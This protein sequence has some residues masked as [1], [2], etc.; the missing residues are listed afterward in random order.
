MPNIHD[1]E[2]NKPSWED[3]SEPPVNVL[4]RTRPFSRRT[5]FLASALTASGMKL[6][7]NS[8]TSIAFAQDEF[9]PGMSEIGPR[10]I[11]NKSLESGEY[12]FVIDPETRERLMT[13]VMNPGTLRQITDRIVDIR[14]NFRAEGSLL[15]QSHLTTP[16]TYGFKLA[17]GT[18][19]EVRF[20]LTTR[21]FTDEQIKEV[22]LVGF[23]WSEEQLRK[24]QVYGMNYQNQPI[25]LD[26]RVT[27]YRH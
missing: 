3:V 22:N 10:N 4:Q 19:T 16:D 5:L 25:N 12:S 15:R 20:L 13:T 2:Q 17:V 27:N 9:V 26:P 24:E 23:R 18:L 11:S 1:S 7:F 8:G 6:A 21:Q 14:N